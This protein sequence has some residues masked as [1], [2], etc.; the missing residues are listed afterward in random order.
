MEK[1]QSVN[2]INFQ[3]KETKFVPND[4]A[5]GLF[6]FLVSQTVITL[7][8]QVLYMV[9]FVHS[10][11]SYVFTLILDAAFVYCVYSITK[12]K[13]FKFMEAIKANKAPKFKQVLLCVLIAIV[14]MFGFSALTNLFLEVLYSAGYT[15]VASDVSI[16]NVWYYLLYVLFICVVPAIA[17]EVLFRGLICNGLKKI[18]TVVAVFGSAFLFMIM[19]GSPDQTVHQFILGI[20]LALA[21]LISNNIWVPI[22]IHFFNNFIAI[23]YAFI[24]QNIDFNIVGEELVSAEQ[25]QIY[26]SEYIIYAVLYALVA[27]CIIY[28]LLRALSKAS[29]SG[30]EVEDVKL[31]EVVA[32]ESIYSL[33]E[34][35]YYSGT[36]FAKEENI[37]E[38]EENKP[39]EV[40]NE[41]QRLLEQLK[42]PEDRLNGSGKAMYIISIVWLVVDWFSALIIGFSMGA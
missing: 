25:T 35:N 23:T 20:I 10:V 17:E 13:N 14:C 39:S 30:E 28:L 31:K 11:W 16:P 8:Y 9:G 32:Q 38:N 1:K 7:I 42:D 33:D 40:D 21:L 29:Q 34:Q 27:G 4:T 22:L 15:S 36:E 41:T 26:L 18:S 5:K 19:H 24:L 2:A 3:F 12:T 6:L 37:T